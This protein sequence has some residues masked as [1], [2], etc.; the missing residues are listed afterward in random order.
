[1]ASRYGTPEGSSLTDWPLAYDDLAP[2]YEWVEWQIGVA[3]SGGTG[4]PRARDYPMPPVRQYE[5]AAVLQRG[6]AALGIDTTAPP[7][8]IN[9]R[10]YGGRD[11][12]I[13][14]GSCVGF[15]CPSDAKSGTQN[16]V[17]PRALAT[18]R[19]TIVTGAHVDRI[20][21]DGSGRATGVTY[22]AETAT[23][24]IEHRRARAKTVIV[25]A[26]AIESAR[27]LLLSGLGNPDQVGRNLQGHY[28]PIAYG[29]FAEEVNGSRGPGVSIAT[30]AY[31]HGNPGVIGG[32]MLADEFV[33]LPAIFAKTATPPDLP[34][35]GA[36]FKDYMR[37]NYRHLLRINGPV[38]E[39]PAP[40]SRVTLARV[41]D[42]L[43]LPV[44]RLSG[45]AHPE[46]IR[47][48]E[49]IRARALGWLA[50]S[51]AREVWGP[52]QPRRLSAGQHQAGTCR[53]GTDPQTSV[54]DRNG[55]LWEHD[56]LFVADGSL[57]P[58]NGGFNPVLT[59][60]AMAARNADAVLAAT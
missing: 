56:N 32:A 54:T 35:W 42:R 37:S 23:G 58:T 7:L 52:P 47:T 11:A 55:R 18:G 49:Y 46:T 59:I 33:L 51:G 6:A 27:L 2:W 36:P 3:G 19:T 34:S 25:S 22:F 43:G 9:T 53:M 28:Y 24:A 8:L 5:R 20:E 12:C 30:T 50:A 31:S 45:L 13:E 1:M 44:A 4:G 40:D 48:A 14:C 17:I 39:I 26:G 15:A 41:T 10:P 60:M 38:H 57:H 21:V 29:L 16:T